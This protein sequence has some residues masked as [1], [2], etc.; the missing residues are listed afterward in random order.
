[1]DQ[2]EFYRQLYRNGTTP[3]TLALTAIQDGVA[4]AQLLALVRAVCN[5]SPS[6]ARAAITEAERLER[7]AIHQQDV[8]RYT[9]LVQAGMKSTQVDHKASLD[10]LSKVRR[11]A[12]LR[13]LFALSL[14]EAK[15]VVVITDGAT[16]L[17]AHQAQLV[18][19]LQKAAQHEETVIQDV[20]A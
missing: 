4:S 5:L 15:E 13:T 8:N 19:A 10:G 7:E 16:S 2:F 3:A 20:G 6:E 11:I 14:V 12:L 9:P 1:M 18:E 17:D